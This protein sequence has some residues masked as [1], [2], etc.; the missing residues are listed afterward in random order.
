ME[1]QS[2]YVVDELRNVGGFNYWKLDGKRLGFYNDKNDKKKLCKI[3]K[4]S[5][6]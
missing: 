4:L 1:L 5:W 3:S 2:K 6:K